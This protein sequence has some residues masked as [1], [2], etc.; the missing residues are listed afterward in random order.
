MATNR[1][2]V[3]NLLASLLTGTGRHKE[4]TKGGGLVRRENP[5]AA[6]GLHRSLGYMLQNSASDG[7]HEVCWDSDSESF[8]GV[9]NFDYKALDESLGWAE[10]TE[11]MIPMSDCAA[12][13]SLVIEHCLEAKNLTLVGAKLAALAIYLDPVNNS[14]FGKTLSEIAA[15]AGVTRASLSKALM[16]F[17]D[18]AAIKLG[19]GKRS[20]CRETCRKAQSAAMAAGCHAS[21]IRSD[22]KKHSERKQAN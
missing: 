11:N 16:N 21:Q 5:T 15:N 12:A 7:V 4:Q 3:G 14:K 1:L 8:E 9:T 6:P 17:R 13:L 2:L 10:D 18:D 22:L 19:I 20:G